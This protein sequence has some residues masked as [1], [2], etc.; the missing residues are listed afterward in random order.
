MIIIDLGFMQV[1]SIYIY[2]YHV[3][4]IYFFIDAK[5]LTF[6]YSCVFSCVTRFDQIHV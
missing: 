4:S 5:R 6:V 3:Y 1:F 2:I